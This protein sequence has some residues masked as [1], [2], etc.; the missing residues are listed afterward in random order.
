LPG[1]RGEQVPL[2]VPR[3]GP[4]EGQPLRDAGPLRCRAVDRDRGLRGP[5]RSPGAQGGDLRRAR[6]RPG[7]R[8][9]LPQSGPR[10]RVLLTVPGARGQ[11]RRR[12]CRTEGIW[13]RRLG[14]TLNRDAASLQPALEPDGLDVSLSRPVEIAWV[15]AVAS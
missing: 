5:G 3:A 2:E 12:S 7:V 8:R 11:A 10:L 9:V 15:M 1:R 14:N 4:P 6:G 13:D